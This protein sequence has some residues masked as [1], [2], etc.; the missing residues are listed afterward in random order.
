[1]SGAAS[2]NPAALFYGPAAGQRLLRGGLA[3]LQRASPALA[4]ALAYR[5]FVTPLPSKRAAR[6][7]PVPVEWQPLGWQAEGLRLVAWQRAQAPDDRG[8]RPRVLL[9]HGW[10]GDAQQMRPLGEALWQA[11]FDPLLLDLPAHGRSA[12]WQT[13]LPQFVQVLLAAGRHFGP[14]HGV[15]GHSLG[16]LAA[17]Q[18]LARGLAA[19]RLVLLALSAPPRQVLAWY[20]AGFGLAPDGVARLRQRLETLAGG[21]P[22]EAYEPAWLAARLPQPTL[23]LHDHEDRA[24]PIVHAQALADALPRARLL[25]SRGLGHRR[26][27]ADP[28]T[29]QAVR[30]HLAQ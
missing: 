6:R 24:A 9:V 26:L 19:E 29:L 11:G 1:M 15:V 23:L 21:A 28:A 17:G 14:L 3:L 13:H 27:L 20:G 5:L 18:A 2:P 22:L 30:V 12:G 25:A 4:A 10:A 7:R 16:A 8:P